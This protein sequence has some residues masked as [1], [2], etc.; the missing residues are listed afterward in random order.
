MNLSRPLSPRALGLLA[1]VFLFGAAVA[2]FFASRAP[3][4]VGR[5]PAGAVPRVV[6]AVPLPGPVP[7]AP[8]APPSGGV[9]PS[10]DVVRVGPEGGTVIAGR[11]AA[12]SEVV[13]FDGDRVVARAMADRYG[14]FVAL[15]AA[16]LPVGGRELT[17]VARGALGGAEVRGE[18]SVVVVVPGAGQASGAP[19]VA[20]LDSRGGARL[21]QEPDGARQ[22]GAKQ[23]GTK[24]GGAR[25]DGAKRA[26][27]SLDVV[28][29][30][31][32]GAVRFSGRAAAGVAVRVYVDNGVV[33]D[34][35]AD[36]AG[37]WGL[38]PGEPIAEGVH[39]LRA[40]AVDGGGRV[41]A[42]V[43]LPFQ[44]AA[45]SLV[46][47][48]GQPGTRSGAGRGQVVVQPGQNLWQLARAAYGSGVRYTVIYQANQGQIRD[49][50]LIYPGQA[51]AVPS[52]R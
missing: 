7:V 44:R 5:L 28:D 23:D 20:L 9:R 39:T 38:V 3:S 46:Q 47:A 37:R 43:E 52:V 18:E 4:A 42:R 41:T 22:D 10:F 15:P 45:V 48:R 33:G 35:R 51:F 27:L 17:L 6:E 11:A 13:V 14:T 21:L 1:A 34:A 19:V 50:R 40:D 31:D 16:P 30:D 24:Q 2:G 8:D 25:Q 49:P 36:G 29:Y 12:G 32:K 26:A